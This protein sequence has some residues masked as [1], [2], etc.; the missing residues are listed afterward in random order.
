MSLSVTHLHAHRDPPY[1]CVEIDPRVCLQPLSGGGEGISRR[2]PDGTSEPVP[3]YFA[4]FIVAHDRDG[5]D[6]RCE[7]FVGID[8]GHDPRWT[9][10][11]SLEGGDLTLSPSILCRVGSLDDP[12]EVGPGSTCGFHGFVRDGKWVPA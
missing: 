7:G 12:R 6:V 3:E 4:G 9:M 1:K 2:L 11:G 8:A 5:F 10:T